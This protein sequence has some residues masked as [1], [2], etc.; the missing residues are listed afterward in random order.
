MENEL[1]KILLETAAS[2]AK[3]SDCAVS[4]VS[5]R[6]KNDPNFFARMEDTSKTFTARTF[7]EVMR[8]CADNWPEGK[9][10]PLALMKWI[11]ETGY[12]SEAA[13]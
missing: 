7:D 1:R 3:A 12:C 4:T 9:Q 10:L 5:R 13:T 11:D 6:A 2:F 8:W